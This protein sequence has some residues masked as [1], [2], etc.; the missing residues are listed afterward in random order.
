MT[1][2]AEGFRPG[3][4]EIPRNTEGKLPEAKIFDL[5][6]SV[7]NAENKALELIV[8]RE[9]VIYSSSAQDREM[10]NRQGNNPGWRMGW[11]VPFGHC[12]QSLAPIGLVRETL[13][14]DGREW[15]YEITQY[16]LRTGVPFAGGLLKWSYEHPDH[17]LY[18]MFGPTNSASIKDEQT[19][20][21]KR[22]QETRYKI[23]WEMATNSSNRIRLIDVANNTNERPDLIDNH[24]ESLNKNGFIS[25]HA[26]EKGKSYSYFKRA[27]T[28]PDKDPEPRDKKH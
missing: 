15:G 26:T 13:S 12:R 14:A 2:V 4:P 17:S 7:G 20:G 27:E 19:L 25:Y 23:F 9:G 21:K 8:M 22:A 16:G 5:L 28:V 10:I 11:A 18:K 24:L 1:E 3:Q 6:S